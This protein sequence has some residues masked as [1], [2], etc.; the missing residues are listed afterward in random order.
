MADPPFR[1]VSEQSEKDIERK[2][3]RDEIGFR[4]RELAA[5]VLRIVRGAGKSYNL[6]DEMT[7]CVRS[8]QEFRDAHGHWPESHAI[9][10]ALRLEDGPYPAHDAPAERWDGWT[11]GV[12]KSM[13]AELH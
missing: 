9:D 12:L 6:L 5:N 13:F 7:A 11:C 10:E 8:F 1:I 2:R 3:T 4:L